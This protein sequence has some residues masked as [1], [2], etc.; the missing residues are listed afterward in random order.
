MILPRDP[1]AIIAS[2]LEDGPETLPVETRRAIVVGL[3][4]Q[5]RAR[6]MAILGGSFVLPIARLATAAAILLA[7][8]LGSIF[9][10]SNRSS[11]PATVPGPSTSAT[12]GAPS[13]GPASV[14]P[15]S[16][17]AP[18]G[19][20]EAAT[21]EPFTSTVY[22]YSIEHPTA[23]QAIPATGPWPQGGLIGPDVQ[24][25]DRFIAR[26]T[27]AVVF[28]AIASQPLPAGT[29]ADRWLANYAQ[30][31]ASRACPV[32][33]DAWTPTTVG[34]AAGRR[35]TFTCD[36]DIGTEVAWVV[37]GRGFVATGQ[38]DVVAA[39]LATIQYR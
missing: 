10:L 33:L 16:A 32:P 7:V 18:S 23:Y 5:P 14:I 26:L 20:P 17:P 34:D 12:A 31:V 19:T 29:S 25:A 38:P 13:S 22:G 11:G 28:V 15:S 6:R 2:W 27:G 24:W 9:I 39:M 8:G 3:R 1:D 35:A 30:A 21:T 37:N 4:T 36:A